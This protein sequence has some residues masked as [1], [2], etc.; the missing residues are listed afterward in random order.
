MNRKK[1]G[2]RY[3]KTNYGVKNGRTAC[4]LKFGLCLDN[5]PFIDMLVNNDEF[6]RFLRK[7]NVEW[8]TLDEYF[9]G[10]NNY[11]PHLIGECIGYAFC[12]PTDTFDESLG[13][14]IALTRAQAVAFEFVDDFYQFV[15][16]IFLNAANE[17]DVLSENS[18]EAM[19]KCNNHVNELIGE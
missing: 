5:I 9:E 7:N 16:N 10:E 1:T 18:V 4:Y 3:L 14:K 8:W 15:Q 19:N 17:F 13:K 11:Q 2:V 12:D 6:N